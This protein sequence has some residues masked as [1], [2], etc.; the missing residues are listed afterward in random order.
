[1]MCQFMY[2]TMNDLKR[3]PDT[4]IKYFRLKNQQALCMLI[5]CL[6]RITFNKR[7]TKF[8]VC[9]IVYFHLRNTPIKQ[10]FLLD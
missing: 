5:S 9:K 2:Y 8:L 3:D 6:I 4:V 10:K 7:E 1:M